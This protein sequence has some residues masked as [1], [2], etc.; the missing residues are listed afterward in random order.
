MNTEL[1]NQ[2]IRAMVNHLE[3][4]MESDELSEKS[5]GHINNDLDYIEVAYFGNNPDGDQ[6]QRYADEIE[7]GEMETI[8]FVKALYFLF[9]IIS[10]HS[11]ELS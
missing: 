5:I 1:N 3:A 2:L 11:S 10:Y 8:G 7:R 6:Q 9:S 4:L